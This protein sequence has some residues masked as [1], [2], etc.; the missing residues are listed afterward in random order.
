MPKSMMPLGFFKDIVPNT[1]LHG[2]VWKPSNSG[3]SDRD[4]M[5]LQILSSYSRAELSHPEDKEAALKGILSILEGIFDD[6]YISGPW[7]KRLPAQLL[8]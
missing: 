8:W 6:T 3:D 5:W 2:A 1:E 4:I 7:R